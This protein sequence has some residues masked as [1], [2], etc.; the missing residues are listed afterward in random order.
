MSDRD[1]LN[2]FFNEVDRRINDEC[3]EF[4]KANYPKAYDVM[5]NGDNTYI[6]I[7]ENLSDKELELI[8]KYSKYRKENSHIFGYYTY[9][10]KAIFARKRL[11]IFTSGSLQN[12]STNCKNRIKKLQDDIN[13]F[14][15]DEEHT[16]TLPVNKSGIHKTIKNVFKSYLSSLKI[17]CFIKSLEQLYCKIS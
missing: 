5:L 4:Y 6:R 14:I 9:M 13:N 7:I 16:I 11:D 8:I 10:L 15:E 2:N 1:T 12:Y 17:K 3:A